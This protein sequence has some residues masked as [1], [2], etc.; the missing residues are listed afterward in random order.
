MSEFKKLKRN[1]KVNTNINKPIFIYILSVLK[2][3]PISF[4]GI[5]I[6]SLLHTSNGSFTFFTKIM[7]YAVVGAGCF[8]S[9]YISNKK[10]KGRGIINGL[11]TAIICTIFY[12]LIIILV[13]KFQVNENILLF[14]LTIIISSVAGGIVSANK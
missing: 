12:T 7:I 10:L 6:T 4:A 13:M 11:I 1:K 3:I 14:L 5:L 2:G 9:G 8:I